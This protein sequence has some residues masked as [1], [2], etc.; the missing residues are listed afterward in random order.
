METGE[1]LPAREARILILSKTYP[2]PSAKHVE[3]SCIGGVEPDGK[4]IR[5]YPLPFRL[6]NDQRQFQKWQ[7]ITALVERAPKDRRPESHRIYVDRIKC[8]SEALPV[9]KEWRARREAIKGVEVFENFDSVELNRQQTGQTIA[10]LRPARIIRLSVTPAD[11]P[12]WTSDELSKLRQAEQEVDLFG[13]RE[14]GSSITQLRKLP[15]DFHYEYECDSDEGPKRFRHKVI[16]WEAG[17]LFWNLYDEHGAD[18]EGRFRKKFEEFMLSRELIFLMGTI[19]RF[20]NKWII[21]SLLY[22]PKQ[23][24]SPQLDLFGS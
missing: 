14:I 10:L 18:F 9:A 19:H 7:W 1:H 3:T 8:D 23:R 5:L 22:P 2:S 4:F 6:L 15:Y 20:P 12:T 17:A 13:D 21:G 24:V 16:D 11:N